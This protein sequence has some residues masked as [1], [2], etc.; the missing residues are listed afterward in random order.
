MSLYQILSTSSL[1]LLPLFIEICNGEFKPLHRT[2]VSCDINNCES[3]TSSNSSWLLPDGNGCKDNVN[4]INICTICSNE[5]NQCE[6][7]SDNGDLI[8]EVETIILK[9][10]DGEISEGTAGDSPPSSVHEDSVNIPKKTIILIVIGSIF[11][12]CCIIYYIC[13]GAIFISQLNKDRN[14]RNLKRTTKQN[15]LV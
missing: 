6:C 1:L 7:V 5:N 8:C 11:S 9:V 4:G 10:V 15:L 13:G 12:L 2:N 3:Y 14:S